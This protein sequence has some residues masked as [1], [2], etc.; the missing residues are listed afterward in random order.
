MSPAVV[1]HPVPRV[2][3]YE[4]VTGRARYAAD[5]Y[6]PGMLY[7]KVLRSKVA[8]ARIKSLET[9]AA[10]Q[11]PGVHCVLTADDLPGEPSWCTYLFLARDRV[12]YTGDALA[13]VAAETREQAEAAIKA[14][15]V[16][17]E[18]LPGVYSIEEALAP[19][20]PQVQE[21]APGNIVQNTHWPVRKGDVAAGFA[22]C[23]VIIEREYR[24]QY[25]EHAYIEPE[26]CVVVPDPVNNGVIV[27]GS[28]QNPYMTRWAV[29]TALG[30]KLGQVHVIQQTLGGSFGGKEEQMGMMCGRAAIM[31]VKTGRPVKMVN[32]REESFIESSK[33]HPFRFRYKIGATKEGKILALE[34]E[35]VDEGGAYNSQAQFMNW[36]A[37]VHAAG[38]YEIPNVKVDVYAVH[39][40][41][42]YAGAMRGYSSPQIIYAQEQLMDELA[43]ALNMDPVELRRQNA[44]RPG[45]ITATGQQ[46]VDQTVPL[47]EVMDAVIARSNYYARREKYARE[48]ARGGSKRRGIG[49]VVSFRGCGLG[50]E[51]YDATGG[52]ITVASDGSVTVRSGLTDNGQGLS[53][54]HAQIVA[55]E[56]GIGME[57]II[58]TRVDTTTMPDGGMTVASRGTFTGGKPMQEAAREIKKILHGVAAEQLGC[59]PEDLEGREGIIYCRQDPARKVTFQ[60]AVRMALQRGY[61]LTSFKWYQPE[62]PVWDRPTGQ[63]KAFPTYTYACVVAEVEVDMET[64]QVEVLKVTAGHDVGQAINPALLQGQI[65]G[66]VAMGLGMALTEEIEF[67]QGRILNPNF[68]EYIIPT[69]LDMPAMETI[70][71]ESEDYHGPFRA[72]SMGEA[73]TEC[74]AAAIASAIADATGKTV[75]ELPANLERVLLGR[76]LKRGGG[77]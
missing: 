33:R 13:M 2:D 52:M 40:N 50:A 31:A 24:T 41:K 55:E 21:Y 25:I 71:Y 65:Y 56:L 32:T 75:R 72:K 17:Y 11:M 14:I 62:P 26:A 70:L 1:N 18:P 6:F 8:H 28:L 67:D 64:G 63:G 5:L 48:R 20:A 43:A 37:C 19:G 38:C 7:G 30:L 16:E 35:L 39:T 9:N 12:R 49:L 3:A 68:D 57:N 44:L 34:A 23:D 47:V 4:K 66:G 73:A 45:S 22:A 54:A 58:Y 77:A 53:T 29:A 10:R 60:E 51:T 69:A 46:L 42:V 61:T 36:R 74:I 76:A 59:R 15:K 27:Y